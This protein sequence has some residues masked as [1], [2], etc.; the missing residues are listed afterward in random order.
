MKIIRGHQ[1]P[2]D[3]IHLADFLNLTFCYKVNYLI[4]G[5]V[6]IWVPIKDFLYSDLS[7][8]CSR[9]MKIS[10]GHQNPRDKIHLWRFFKPYFL[11]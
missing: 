2:R 1:N 3:N 6:G 4:M 7:C 5:F 8:G 10:R 9:S 11:L